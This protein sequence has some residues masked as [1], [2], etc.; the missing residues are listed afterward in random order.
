MFTNFSILNKLFNFYFT[1]FLSIIKEIFQLIY[2]K[3]GIPQL[4]IKN[5]A[6]QDEI[7]EIQKA[8][9]IWLVKMKS[10][11]S[12]S[13]I[14]SEILHSVFWVYILTGIAKF[15]DRFYTTIFQNSRGGGQNST[16]LGHFI[17]AL[18]GYRLTRF[19][20]PSLYFNNN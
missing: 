11:W 1:I 2:L 13:E 6:R 16:G 10:P 20:W 15:G 5:C 4:T 3:W 18:G 7:Y 8:L 14:W 19:P 12:R 9:F 17:S